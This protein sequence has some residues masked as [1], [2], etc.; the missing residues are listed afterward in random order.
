MSGPPAFKRRA[1]VLA[2]GFAGAVFLPLA[3]L[4]TLGDP[5]YLLATRTL[6]GL[7]T[8]PHLAETEIV[9]LGAALRN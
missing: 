9:D 5:L 8:G 3:C 6:S 1:S 7:A 4:Y 2:W